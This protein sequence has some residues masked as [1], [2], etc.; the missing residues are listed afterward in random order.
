MGVGEV[1]SD[2]PGLASPLPSF[3][4]YYVSMDNFAA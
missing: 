4:G 3:R 2:E 1:V